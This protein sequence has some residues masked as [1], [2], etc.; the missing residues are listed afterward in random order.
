MATNTN[1]ASVTPIVCIDLKKNRIRV[2]KV[3][4]R[5]LNDPDYILLLI[6]PETGVLAIKETV[7]S[8]H[9]ALKIRKEMLTDGNCYE[10][11]SKDLFL[12]LKSIRSDWESNKSYRIYGECNRQSQVAYFR[13]KDVVLVEDRNTYD[14]QL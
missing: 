7:S 12:A 2:H 11:Y 6:N 9:L 1:E 3:T 13:M 4:L 5:A 8:D 14:R 10:I